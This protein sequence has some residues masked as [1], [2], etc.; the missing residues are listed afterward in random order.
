MS[1]AGANRWQKRFD[2]AQQSCWESHLFRR[3]LLITVLLLSSYLSLQY[4]RADAG[5]SFLSNTATTATWS[6]G[7]NSR[8][9]FATA[10]VLYSRRHSARV[11][12]KYLKQNL[13]SAGGILEEVRVAVLIT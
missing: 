8:K 4:L 11:L 6:S 9:V 12:D 3:I 2:P 10:L 13:V 5:C 1:V 7:S